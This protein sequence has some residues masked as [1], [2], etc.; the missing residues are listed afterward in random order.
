L[1]VSLT[2][3]HRLK[4]G[5]VGHRFAPQR[6]A[7]FDHRHVRQR[8]PDSEY[9]RQ[10]G[11]L[12]DANRILLR[13][14]ATIRL[15]HLVEGGSLGHACT[16]LGVPVGLAHS[17]ENRLSAWLRDPASRDAFIAAVN[18][19]ADEYDEATTS[20]TTARGGSAYPIG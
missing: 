6:R 16:L 7:N 19:L 20:S 12:A 10:F 11:R 4:I 2:Q 18:T 13:R 8:L 15:V 17:T 14:L 3:W 1:Q 5:S 9:D